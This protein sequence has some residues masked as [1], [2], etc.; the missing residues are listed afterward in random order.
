MG[1][2]RN[3]EA[4]LCSFFCTSLNERQRYYLLAQIF[5]TLTQLVLP[6]NDSTVNT[7]VTAGTLNFLIGNYL[8]ITKNTSIRLLEN[9]CN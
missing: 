4:T 1:Q 6:H 9:Y 2:Y 3:H 7:F 5:F 8:S